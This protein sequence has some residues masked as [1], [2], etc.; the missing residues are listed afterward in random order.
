[1]GDMC[2][3]CGNSRWDHIAI[4]G[5]LICGTEFEEEEQPP[6]SCF[7]CDDGWPLVDRGRKRL[8]PFPCALDDRKMH[9]PRQSTE[10]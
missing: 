9:E 1:M 5:A 8:R 3:H 4:G 10:P 6:P 7:F 2:R